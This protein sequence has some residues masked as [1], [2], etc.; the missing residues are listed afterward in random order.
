ML[1]LEA[2]LKDELDQIINQKL[3]RLKIIEQLKAEIKR[4]ENK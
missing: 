4:D 3:S 1:N 2:S